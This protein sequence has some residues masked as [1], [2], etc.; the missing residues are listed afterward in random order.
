[1][2]LTKVSFSMINGAVINAIDSGAV[3][4]GVTDNLAA[5]QAWQNSA[6]AQN[7]NAF[8]P[9]GVYYC[10]DNLI[11]KADSFGTGMNNSQ[12][13]FAAGK[14][15][16]NYVSETEYYPVNISNIGFVSNKASY[17]NAIDAGASFDP[18][19][20]DPSVKRLYGARVWK[21]NKVTTPNNILSNDPAERLNGTGFWNK[22]FLQWMQTDGVAPDITLAGTTAFNSDTCIYYG[23]GAGKQI[24]GCLFQGFDS[25][26][27]AGTYVINLQSNRFSTMRKGILF[28]DAS[29]ISG[30]A[31]ARIT[32][33]SVKNNYFVDCWV[34]IYAETMLQ[35]VVDSENVFEPTIVGVYIS[36]G[37]ASGSNISQNYFEVG[38]TAVYHAPN[39]SFAGQ[40]GPNFTNA[41]YIRYAA[42]LN[43][44]IDIQVNGPA[45]AH[46]KIYVAAGVT[47]SSIPTVADAI[48]SQPF[49]L[50]NG[51]AIDRGAA[52][53]VIYKITGVSGTSATIV[54]ENVPG[55]GDTPV[56]SATDFL[57]PTVTLNNINGLTLPANIIPLKI[58]LLNFP[59]ELVD[60]FDADAPVYS[61]H[62][63]Y[64]VFTF[65]TSTSLY[66]PH[67]FTINGRVS[68]V[69]VTFAEASTPK[70]V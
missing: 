57:A 20:V 7:T 50:N 65:N 51:N 38:H 4:D 45:E 43:S 35:S 37:G 3:G 54:V 69:R 41:A 15:F 9:A 25:F 64:F 42:W 19:V 39:L 17:W 47:K 63:V 66:D 27:I 33:M 8:L 49:F 70:T 31:N 16:R 10:S 36:T 26:V 53:K 68:Y 58:E 2:S 28:I 30:D 6:N 21:G 5:L 13:I 29:Y 34:G 22:D 62:R 11:I 44:G 40:I 46:Q 56:S 12:I 67:N 32:T 55:A 1:M 48:I 18:A 23:L 52:K 61:T 14:G 60:T 59:Q 24:T